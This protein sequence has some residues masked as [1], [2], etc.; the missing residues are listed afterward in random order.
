MSHWWTIYITQEGVRFDPVDELAG[1]GAYRTAEQLI[2]R[3]GEK[4]AIS[5]I[6]PAGEQQLLAS[7]ILNL[8]KDHSP[9]RISARGGLGAVMGS[10]RIKAIVFD[11]AARTYRQ[12]MI[13]KHINW[14]ASVSQKH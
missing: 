7:G 8:D 13:R 12:H 2:Q 10:K 14:P 3:Y 5:L 9:S 1:A 4:A 11:P 6:G